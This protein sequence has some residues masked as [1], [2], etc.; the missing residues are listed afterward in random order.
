MKSKRFQS[1]WK[2]TEKCIQLE[3]KSESYR[4]KSFRVCRSA[5]PQRDWR[6]QTA[7]LLL[8]VV[9][10]LH[11]GQVRTD[12]ELDRTW[13]SPGSIF[14]LLRFLFCLQPKPTFLSGHVPAATKTTDGNPLQSRKH[15]ILCEPGF[16]ETWGKNRGNPSSSSHPLCNRN[17]KED[18]VVLQQKS[19]FSAAFLSNHCCSTHNSVYRRHSSF[20]VLQYAEPES[21]SSES[22]GSSS[23][24]LLKEIRRRRADIRRRR[25]S[26]EPPFRKDRR[27]GNEVKKGTNHK[28]GAKGKRRKGTMPLYLRRVFFSIETVFASLSGLRPRQN[29]NRQRPFQTSVS[30]SNFWCSDKITLVV[31]GVQSSVT[32]V[33]KQIKQK[34]TWIYDKGQQTSLIYL[35]RLHDVSIKKRKWNQPNLP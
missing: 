10:L 24:L 19:G 27:E 9:G 17:L 28:N 14:F 33:T 2:N 16:S 15:R 34:S 29:R 21:S 5:A 31:F 30:D 22:S 32:M 7:A 23:L 18:P 11:T 6:E 4:R 25:S 26:P 35:Y 1:W 8:A 12:Q 13:S 3:Q 20:S